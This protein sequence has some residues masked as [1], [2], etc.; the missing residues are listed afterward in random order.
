MPANV[1]QKAALFFSLPVRNP[2]RE[3][4]GALNK[5]AFQ[6][7]DLITLVLQNG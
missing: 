4:S 2:H 3:F 5:P 7:I 1:L 6:L